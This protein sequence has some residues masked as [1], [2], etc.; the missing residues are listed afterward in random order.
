MREEHLTRVKAREQELIIGGVWL[1]DHDILT[2]TLI[3]DILF[4][5][6]SMMWVSLGS[7]GGSYMISLSQEV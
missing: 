7:S 1:G 6:K 2:C 3:Q 5:L 4:L